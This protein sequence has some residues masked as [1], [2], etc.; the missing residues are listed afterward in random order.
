MHST[1]DTTLKNNLKSQSKKVTFMR[2]EP[3]EACQVLVT[4]IVGPHLQMPTRKDPIT[5]FK[6]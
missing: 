1:V 4:T 6:T 5:H 3:Y 2:K